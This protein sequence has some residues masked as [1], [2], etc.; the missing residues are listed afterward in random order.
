MIL[1]NEFTKRRSQEYDPICNNFKKKSH[2]KQTKSC[3]WN[4]T[5]YDKDL[6]NV[7]NKALQKLKN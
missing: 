1:N 5:K 4:L 3:A 7:N 6:Y 2:N